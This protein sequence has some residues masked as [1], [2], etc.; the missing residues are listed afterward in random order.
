VRRSACSAGSAGTGCSTPSRTVPFGVTRRP[1][2]GGRGLDGVIQRAPGY[3]NPAMEI[4]DEDGPP[5]GLRGVVPPGRQ[6]NPAMEILDEDGPPGGFR[7]VVPPGRQSNPA[8]EILDG[9]REAQ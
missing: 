3:F 1:A 7:G 8:M 4:L 6:S 5:G 2:D 9:E